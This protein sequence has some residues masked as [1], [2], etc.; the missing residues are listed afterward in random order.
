M[1]MLGLGTLVLAAGSISG[2]TYEKRRDR[3]FHFPPLDIGQD[4][5]AD[6][7]ILVI[8]LGTGFNPD[9]QLPANNQVSGAYLS[10][11]LEGVRILRACPDARLLVSVAGKADAAEK[12]L[13]L[14]RMIELLKIDS[15]RVSIITNAQSTSNEAQEFAARYNGEQVVV[16][17]SAGHMVRAMQIFEDASLSPMAAPADYGFARAGSPGEKIWPRWVPSA[18]GVGSNHQWLYE[19]IA[20]LWHLISGR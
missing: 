10:R 6:R 4:I 18:D 1:V 9:P 5:T 12:R 20:S 2:L 7:P 16:V 13:F 8:V 17:T 11:L 14:D 15:A 3:E 19:Q